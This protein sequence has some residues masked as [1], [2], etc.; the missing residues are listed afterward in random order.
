MLRRDIV[1]IAAS[2]GGVAALCRVVGTLTDKFPGTLLVVQHTSAT[3]PGYLDR[4]LQ[5]HTSMPVSYA[6]AGEVMQ[7]GHF[8]LAPPGCHLTVSRRGTM[9]LDGGPRVNFVRP[10]ADPLFAS[11]A[12]HFGSRVAGVVLTGFDGDGAA[13]L[14]AI[15]QAGGVSIVQHPAEAE[16]PDMPMSALNRDKPDYAI[17][18]GELGPLLCA[19]A[20]GRDGHQH[21]A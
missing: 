3:S 5:R 7:R 1:V 10:A 4:L 12:K 14:Q 19:L 11:A 6:N 2:K 20:E 15:K 17:S 13:G 18:L 8:Y 9:A 16:A 21:L